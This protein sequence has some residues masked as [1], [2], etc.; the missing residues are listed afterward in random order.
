MTDQQPLSGDLPRDAP[1]RFACE[2]SHQTEYARAAEAEFIYYH[3]TADKFTAECPACNTARPAKVLK[4][5]FTGQMLVCVSTGHF[6]DNPTA[7]PTGEARYWDS[8]TTTFE[9]TLSPVEMA[10]GVFIIRCGECDELLSP[11]DQHEGPDAPEVGYEYYE[12]PACG[13]RTHPDTAEVVNV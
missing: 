3:E 12:C 13:G 6:T 5:A 8:T 2:C 11:E 4:G 10:D 7:E 1:L 9:N